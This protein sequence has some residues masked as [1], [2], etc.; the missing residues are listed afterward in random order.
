[1]LALVFVLKPP[2]SLLDLQKSLQSLSANPLPWVRMASW[3]RCTPGQMQHPRVLEIIEMLFTQVQFASP[4][5]PNY[6][7]SVC[8]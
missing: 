5:P 2:H 4:L 7:E 6:L 3:S 1:M 8:I